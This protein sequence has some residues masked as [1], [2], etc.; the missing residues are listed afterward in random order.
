M[1]PIVDKS[2]VKMICVDDFA[3]R[4]RFLYGTVMV[5]LIS[6][7]SSPD[8]EMNRLLNIKN[9]ADRIRYA[10]EKKKCGM[11]VQEISMILHASLKTVKKY[12]QADADKVEENKILHERNHDLAVQ[13]KEQEVSEARRMR[14][15]GYSIEQIARELHRQPQTI[16][17]FLD[18]GYSVVNGHYN[19]RIPGK[20]APYEKQV[21][22]LR[23]KGVTYSQIHKTITSQGYSGS[24]ASLRMFIQKEKYRRGSDFG[25]EVNS[26]YMSTDVIHRHSLSSFLYKKTDEAYS[27]SKEQYEKVIEKYPALAQLFGAIQEFYAMI[28]SKESN[29]I[30]DWLKKAETF[31]IPE[32]NTYINGIRRDIS[33]V[34]NGIELGYN[35]G[36]AEGSV[37]KIKVAKRIMYGRNSFELL[38]A[39]VLLQEQYYCSFN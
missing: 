32:L 36:L 9:T 31:N 11:S 22:D 12:L 25:N 23:S 7:E 4:K 29:R 26:D 39:K 19:A 30:R 14:L 16:K 28:N 35:N 20:L 3:L 2:T 13:Q 21:L 5:D 33:A 15:E 17:R 34:K 27:I 1:P 8:P 18:P 24:I 6:S 37:N 38:K 10:Q